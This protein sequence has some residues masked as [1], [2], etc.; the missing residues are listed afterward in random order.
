MKHT[1][2]PCPPI[3]ARRLYEDDKPNGYLESDN[4]FFENNREAIL[5]FL[6]NSE[7]VIKFVN[8]HD[9][10]VAALKAMLDNAAAIWT[11]KPMAMDKW[12][13]TVGSARDLLAKLEGGAK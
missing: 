5:W 9:E 10:L 7:S 2:T 8:A 12:P 11:D 3:K 6:D 4:D 13:K 1:P